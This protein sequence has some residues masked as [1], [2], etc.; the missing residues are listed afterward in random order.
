MKIDIEFINNKIDICSVNHSDSEEISKIWDSLRESYQDWVSNV[1]TR[2]YNPGKT[3]LNTFKIG[4]LSSWWMNRLQKKDSFVNNAWLNRLFLLSVIKKFPGKVNLTTDDSLLH[5]S[6]NINDLNTLNLC[7]IY[8][9][10][11]YFIKNIISLFSSFTNNLI[12]Y[13]ALLLIN[14][15]FDYESHCKSSNVWFRA[16]FPVN[17]IEEDLCDRIYKD[18]PKKKSISGHE[19]IYLVIY[20]RSDKDKNFINFFKHILKINNKLSSNAINYISL[21]S[22]LVLSDLIKVYF[23]NFRE[24]IKFK[25]LCGNSRFK[26]LFTIDNMDVS[27]I[28]LNEWCDGY[29]GQYQS[30]IIEAIAFKKFLNLLP[31]GQKIITYGETFANN[32]PSYHFA[33]VLKPKTLF[34]AFQHAMNSRNK[35]FTCHRSKDF[36]NDPLKKYNEYSPSPDY[37]L[38]QGKHYK[39]ILADFFDISRII[40]IGNENNPNMVQSNNKVNIPILKSHK[41]II[42]LTPSIGGEFI[43]M[44]D[45]MARYRRHHEIQ[46]F[47]SPHPVESIAKIDSHYR[48]ACPDLDLYITNK[49][50]TLELA[51]HCDLVISGLS[52][53]AIEVRGLGIQSIRYIPLGIM[54]QHDEDEIPSF[55]TDRDIFDWLDKFLIEKIKFCDLKNKKIFDSYYFSPETLSDN[56]WQAIA[57]IE[58][59]SDNNRKTFK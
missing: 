50:K 16:L 37:F 5:K 30:S 39:N 59:H 1:G 33:K 31:D 25:R 4:E 47:L 56:F 3:I 53:I 36:F 41:K 9:I 17:W 29:Y 14:R 18:L 40:I 27:Y 19:S 23:Y 22:V 20:K 49:W 21:E 2:E 7:R 24:Y 46:F 58:M 10:D 42:L 38:T 11:S 12:V 13:L 15:K 35:M 51:K 57:A 28:L 45:L 54:P 6:I 48:N 26:K 32:R 55:R 44:L 43:W 34:I 8:K 52:T